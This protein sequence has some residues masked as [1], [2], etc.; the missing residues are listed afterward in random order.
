MIHHF[1]TQCIIMQEK[2]VAE[3]MNIQKKIQANLPKTPEN[4]RS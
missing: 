3:K 2:I 1:D 4:K